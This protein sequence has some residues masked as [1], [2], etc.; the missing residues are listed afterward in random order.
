MAQAR[1]LLVSGDNEGAGTGTRRLVTAVGLWHLQRYDNYAG[2]LRLR[3]DNYKQNELIP[4][5]DF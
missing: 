5:P 4:Y 3:Q 2:A 1:T